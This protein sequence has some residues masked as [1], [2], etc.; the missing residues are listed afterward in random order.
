MTTVADTESGP[1]S[2]G[3]EWHPVCGVHQIPDGGGV[4]GIVDGHPVALFSVDGEVRCLDL[5]DPRSGAPVLS[6]GILGGDDD[7]RWVA[8]PMYKDRFDL[9][10]GECLDDSSV[11][12]HAWTVRV[13]DGT[14]SV[15]R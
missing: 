9:A 12:V 6:R 10:T 4:A 14:V 13:T 15:A 5:V 8:S 3:S 7:R 2:V 11:S 1:R